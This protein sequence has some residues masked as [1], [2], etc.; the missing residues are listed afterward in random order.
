MFVQG[1]IRIGMILACVAPSMLCFSL[2]AGLLFSGIDQG[3]GWLLFIG[4]LG[5][6]IPKRLLKVPEPCP[7]CKAHEA[8]QKPQGAYYEEVA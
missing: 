3:W 6:D 4:A 1:M 7:T 2:A 8:Y 5:L